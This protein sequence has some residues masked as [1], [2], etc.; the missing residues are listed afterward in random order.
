MKRTFVIISLCLVV[1]LAFYRCSKNPSSPE[2]KI[3][4][5]AS[6]VT[7][8]AGGETTKTITVGNG[9]NG[10]LTWNAQEAVD[11]SWLSISPASGNAGDQLTITINPTNLSSGS[12]DATI[13]I[14]SNGGDTILGVLALISELLVSPGVVNFESSVSSI[15][16]QIQ[17]G[18]A[19]NLNWT[20]STLSSIPWLSL[21]QSSGENSLTISLTVD[22]SVVNI[23]SHVG[24]LVLNSTG[25]SQTIS[26]SMSKWPSSIF[27]E[28][29]SG[30]LTDWNFDDATGTINNGILELT[31]TSSDFFGVIFHVIFPIR[32]APWLYRAAFGRKN[33]VPSS[34]SSMVMLTDDDGDVIVPA[35]RFDIIAD[36]DTNWLAGGFVFNTTTGQGLWGYFENGIGKSSLLGIGA[37]EINDVSWAMKPNKTME[38]YVDGSLFYQTDEILALQN[39]I[40]EDIATGL[41]EIHLWAGPNV[42]TIADWVLVRD[43]DI[44]GKVQFQDSPRSERKRAILASAMQAAYTQLRSGAWRNMPSLRQAI[45][46]V[47]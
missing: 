18:G 5:S 40:G 15:E 14:T 11:E 8:D 4:L 31:G 24:S 27:L 16:L 1:G 37:N 45:N 29:F 43:V 10:E 46:Q 44:P 23:G 33:D 20:I 12:H 6:S 35:F 19:G 47:R 26:V 38:V 36:P 22:R 41:G 9:G 17:N 2:P 13:Q 30:N 34:I 39:Q 28:E 42:T 3:S 7:F 21:S 32:S 25:G